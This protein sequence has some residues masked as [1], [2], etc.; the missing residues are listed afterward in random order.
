MIFSTPKSLVRL[1]AVAPAIVLLGSMLAPSA[2]FAQTPEF[3]RV[4][5]SIVGLDGSALTV[6]SRQGTDVT[7]K[8]AEDLRVS[9]VV[10]A[11]ISDIKPGVFIGTAA[12]PKDG[13]SHAIEV[14][15]F[16]EALRGA[17]EG[18]RPWDLTPNSTMT[19]G[20]IGSAVEGVDG[21][22]VTVAYKGGE[23]KV[24]IGPDT[25]VVTLGPADKSDIKPGTVV[26]LTARKRED[27]SLSANSV[28]V[29]KNGVVPPM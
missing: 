9:T 12:A 21:P 1:A 7:V 4:R 19:N 18:D 20:T 22:T 26:F 25:P 8:L 15:I 11:S 3:V 6:K 17:G 16:P 24:T 2:S 29:G 14:L 5:G 10:K 27:G 23:R 28:T 13:A